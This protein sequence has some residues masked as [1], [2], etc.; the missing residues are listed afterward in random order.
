MKTDYFS[1]FLSTLEPQTTPKPAP[2]EVSAT[3]TGSPASVNLDLVL[4]SLTENGGEV[5][6][7]QLAQDTGNGVND[8]IPAIM[9]LQEFG[10]VSFD[11]TAVRL[12]QQGKDMPAT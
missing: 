1:T 5:T 2:V 10:L 8:L 4:K 6:L 7:P 12:T 9:Q 11:R 3:R